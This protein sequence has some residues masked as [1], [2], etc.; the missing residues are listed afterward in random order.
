M[1][2]RQKLLVAGVKPANIILDPGIGFGKTIE[3][4]WDLLKFASLVPG[5]QVMIGYSKKSFLGDQRLTIEKNLEAGRIAVDSGAKYLRL[6][7]DLLAAHF[8]EF[9]LS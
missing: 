9:V 5:H 2:T 4:N 8:D 6:H 1:T 3:T 7:A